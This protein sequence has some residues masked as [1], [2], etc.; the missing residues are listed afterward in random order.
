MQ[1]TLDTLRLQQEQLQTEQHRFLAE[2]LTR[3]LGFVFASRNL[4]LL[5]ACFKDLQHHASALLAQDALVGRAR[6]LR[7]RRAVFG[8]LKSHL[9][10]KRLEVAAEL[11][12]QRANHVGV[13]RVPGQSLVDP[14]THGAAPAGGSNRENTWSRPS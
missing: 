10:E 3:V 2:K 11:R 9:C 7:A 5:D 14:I 4:P 12:E 13:R 6:R 8:A 1:R